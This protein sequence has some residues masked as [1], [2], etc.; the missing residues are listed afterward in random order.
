MSRH[1]YLIIAHSEFP[2][3]ELLIRALDDERNDIYVHIDQKVDS[4]PKLSTVR[5]GLFLL[6]RRRDVRWGDVS[7]VQVEYDLFAEAYGANRG[8]TYYH[9]LSGVDLPLKSQ[10]YIHNFFAQHEGREFVG[11]YSG[12]DLEVSIDRKVRRRHIFASDFKGSGP[13]FLLKKVLRFAWLRTQFAL[14]L[15]RYQ[16]IEFKK[17]TQWVSLTHAFVGYMLERRAETERLYRQSFCADEI[18]VQTLLWHSPYREQIFDLEHEGRG[19]MREIGWSDN[20][21][22]DYSLRDKAH[23]LR[24]E[25]LWAR[26]FNSSDMDFLRELLEEAGVLKA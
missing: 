15:R 21:L 26:K 16:D 22:Y 13:I 1:A 5:A 2:V 25:G 12:A 6:Q 14:G 24:S 23:L 11:Y 3:L 8:Y 17:G 9:L 4:L 18:F 20:T 7:I 10:D 19:C